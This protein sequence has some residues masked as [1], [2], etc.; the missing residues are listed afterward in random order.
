MKK[1]IAFFDIDNT[2]ISATSGKVMAINGY[3][4]GLLSHRNMVEGIAL[5]LLYRFKFLKSENVIRLMA[6]WLKGIPEKEIIDFSTR[7][8]DE[9]LKDKIREKARLEVDFHN[10]H[11]GFTVIISATTRYLC[12]LIKNELVMGD[13]ICS[14]LE[15]I[16]GRYSGLPLGTYCYGK[17]KLVQAADYCNKHGFDLGEAYYYGDSASDIP[18][19]EVVRHPMC[20]TPDKRLEK[21]ARDRGWRI[22]HW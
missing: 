5:S 16:D 21:V 18:L 15:V 8:F 20:V 1:Y 22:L 4:A 3:R 13:F 17:E 11:G 7:L 6:K 2:V 10:E 14:E 9:H 12:G 19:L